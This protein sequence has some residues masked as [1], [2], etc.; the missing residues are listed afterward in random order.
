MNESRVVLLQLAIADY[1]NAFMRS[2]VASV[3]GLE[4]Q[5]GEHYFEPTTRTSAVVKS[6]PGVMCIKNRY[7]RGMVAWQSLHWRSV[8]RAEVVVGELNPRILSTWCVLILR[9]LL[10]RRTLLW[11]HAWPRAGAMSRTEPVRHV[12]R[13]LASG[14]VLYTESQKRELSERYG[15]GNSIAVAPNALYSVN[16]MEVAKGVPADF[17]YVGRLIPSKKVSLLVDAFK[18]FVAKVPEARLHLVGSGDALEGLQK[19][20]QACSIPNV[21]FHGHVVEPKQL[22]D[23]YGCCVASVSPGYVGLSITQS[24]SFGV[25]MIISRDEPHSPEIECAIEGVNCTFFDSDSPESL[26]AQMSYWS[27][28]R[29]ERALLSERI[30]ADCRERYSVERMVGGFLE[31]FRD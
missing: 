21:E 25:P 10:G 8:L 31:A 30:A 20:V 22:M 16:D 7:F 23:L 5:V 9:R 15:N 27:A 29:S 11:G 4:V 13:K 24:F 1:R 19:Q 18:L 14:L 3:P 2:L 17:I 12:M 6:L 28:G 26:A